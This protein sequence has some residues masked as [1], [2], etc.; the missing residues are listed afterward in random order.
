MV[1]IQVGK[2]GQYRRE[3]NDLVMDLDIDFKEALFGFERKYKSLKG[4]EQNISKTGIS[5]NGSQIVVR[6][7]GMPVEGSSQFGDLRVHLKYK[8]PNF[9]NAS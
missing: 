2:H 8:Y 1:K 7:E 6:N 3:G 4:I 5:Q 9:L